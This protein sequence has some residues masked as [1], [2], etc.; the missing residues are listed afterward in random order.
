MQGIILH[1]ERVDGYW[2]VYF[3]GEIYQNERGAYCTTEIDLA[4]KE[5]DLK[6]IL[7]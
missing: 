2:L 7:E 4:V 1:P 6:I 3:D 5:E